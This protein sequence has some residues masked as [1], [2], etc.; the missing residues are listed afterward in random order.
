[1]YPVTQKSKDNLGATPL[2]STV[3]RRMRAGSS[4]SILCV[5]IFSEGLTEFSRHFL[6]SVFHV[7]HFYNQPSIYKLQLLSWFLDT[8]ATKSRGILHIVLCSLFVV[9]LYESKLSP[10]CIYNCRTESPKN[11]P[12]GR[13]IKNP[14]YRGA[15][16]V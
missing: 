12:S 9:C 3:S 15:N 8:L 6:P 10:R 13:G 2:K 7:N 1:M 4:T 11:P 16:D 5:I 14:P